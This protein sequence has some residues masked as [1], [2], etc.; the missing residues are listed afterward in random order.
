M[1]KLSDK[2]T[3]T[4]KIT[5]DVENFELRALLVLPKDNALGIFS[6]IGVLLLMFST[7]LETNLKEFSLNFA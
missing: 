4:V 3:D 2:I 1:G 5:A 7:G 6:K